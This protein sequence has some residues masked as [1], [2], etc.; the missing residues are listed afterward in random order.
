M[1]KVNEDMLIDDLLYTASA[2]SGDVNKNFIKNNYGNFLILNESLMF[3]FGKVVLLDGIVNTGYYERVL[4]R[5]ETQAVQKF[6]EFLD[7]NQNCLLELCKN[8][9]NTMD[10]IDFKGYP[11]WD[12]L[13]RYNEKDFKDLILGYYSTFGNDLYS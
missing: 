2:F 7:S 4:Q 3:N 8:Y 6:A 12:S 11:F 9:C 1:I 13:R 5:K 10:E